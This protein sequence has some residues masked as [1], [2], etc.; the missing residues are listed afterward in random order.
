MKKLSLI[1]IFILLVFI[2]NVCALYSGETYNIY[3]GDCAYLEVDIDIQPYQNESEYILSPEC[4]F[5]ELGK[6]KCDCIDNYLS[7]DITPKINSVG[8]Y[9]ITTKI[10]KL[11]EE[12]AKPSG[13]GGGGGGGY[14]LTPKVKEEIIEVEEKE[15][16]KEEE[17]KGLNIS[18]AKEIAINSECGDRLKENYYCNNDTETWWIDL[19]IE[20]EYCNPACV[21]NVVT[22]EASIN[23]RCTGALPPEEKEELNYAFY[24][25]F[26]VL[27]I[28]CIAL[29]VYFVHSYKK[30][31]KKK[32][33]KI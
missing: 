29:I 17:C 33:K 5:I 10:Y 24:L 22:K 14:M 1:L 21:V 8:N 28:I 9:T 6:Y 15:E 26:C 23:W 4:E 11:I 30:K 27:I 25:L 7:L 3:S 13:G 32:K 2:I 12:E 16:I 31:K 18:E 20:K 19:G